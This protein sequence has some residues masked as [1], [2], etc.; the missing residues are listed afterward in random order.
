[1]TSRT[2]EPDEAL[3]DEE[4]KSSTRR[5]VLFGVVLLGL[6]VLAGGLFAVLRDDRPTETAEEE[7]PEVTFGPERDAT[8]IPI[9]PPNY[10]P[11]IQLSEDNGPAGAR[12]TLQGVNF[13][14][15]KDF[16]PAEV[17]W[18]R[19]E[20]KPMVVVPPGNRFSVTLTIPPDAPVLTE[21]H[22]VVI[23]QKEKSGKVIFQT[24]TPFYVLPRR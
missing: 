11:V 13:N 10:G 24:S 17:Y 2:Q 3:G 16:R 14:V 20:G 4:R 8:T 6:L 21:G 18:D 5:Y 22:N 7:I 9:P 19:A 12:V 23:V 1:L 15:G